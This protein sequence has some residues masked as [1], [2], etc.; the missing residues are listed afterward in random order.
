MTSALAYV[1]S[2]PCLIVFRV[3]KRHRRLEPS[4]RLSERTSERT[5]EPE[6]RSKQGI[7][8]ALAYLVTQF[9]ELKQMPTGNLQDGARRSDAFGTRAVSDPLGPGCFF[10][11]GGGV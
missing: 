6:V 1:S 9:L 2:V 8:A 7:C 5:R 11:V 3:P 4:A 10:L